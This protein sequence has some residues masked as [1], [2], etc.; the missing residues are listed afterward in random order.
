M[1]EFAKNMLAQK[2]MSQKKT[3][4]FSDSR[5][6]Q[7]SDALDAPRE[8][9]MLLP[10]SV[11]KYGEKNREL[12][13]PQSAVDFYDATIGN[14][15][16]L[17]KGELGY[18]SVDNPKF[19]KAASDMAMNVAGGGLLGSKIP[20]AVPENA[21][22][23]FAGKTATNFPAK[24]LLQQPDNKKLLQLNNELDVIRHELTKGRMVLGDE[25]TDQLRKRKMKL[26]DALD[27]E[28]KL[29]NKQRNEETLK[30]DEFM[31]KQDY[32]SGVA[33]PVS[34]FQGSKR[35]F[36][37]GL[38]K[39]PDGQYRFEIDDTVAKMK[40]LDNVFVNQGQFAEVVA[41]VAGAK[42]IQLDAMGSL[43]TF[44]NSKNAVNLSDIL[45]HK[46]LFDNYPQLKNL[47]VAFYN[48]PT[49]SAYGSFYGK[50]FFGFD[51]ININ[52]G[53]GKSKLGE[54]INLDTPE[55]KEKILDV[56][57]HEIQHKIQDI[58]NFTPGS[59]LKESSIKFL[60]FKNRVETDKLNAYPEFK[61]F[62]N[63]QIE[64]EPLYKARYIKELDQK[65]LK[66]RVTNQDVYL[67]NLI[68]IS[69]VMK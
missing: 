28:Y 13:F 4:P 59:N 44:F 14:M 32:R 23:I 26:L 5:F 57:V 27:D 51:G 56:L 64:I 65:L 53:F 48:D 18:P 21:L 6:F 10:F 39:L 63:Y 42:N 19:T 31:E 45:N 61:Q 29:L 54:N 15:G 30:L 38:F 62:D 34:R 69:L 67:I 24:S 20:G 8:R 33:N 9:G 52:A 12:A 2:L 25:A 17:F 7:P 60:S 35:E 55:N 40:N 41:N 11:Q 37:T 50:K 36:G 43:K 1:A 49:S 46:E 58:E 16:K 66:V 47:K 68:G 3:D 22:G